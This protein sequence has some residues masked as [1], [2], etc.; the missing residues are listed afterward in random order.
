[1]ADALEEH[2]ERF[3]IDGR[4]IANL[5]FADNIDALAEDFPSYSS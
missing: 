4:N 2:G 3:S 5:W 1:M